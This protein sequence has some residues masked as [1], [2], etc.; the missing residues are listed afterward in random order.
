MPHFAVVGFLAAAELGAEFHLQRH[1]PQ[2]HAA[3]QVKAQIVLAVFGLL[4]YLFRLVK[5]ELRR[6]VHA[7]RADQLGLA[8]VAKAHLAEIVVRLEHCAGNV[9]RRIFAGLAA[10]QRQIQLPVAQLLFAAKHQ[11]HDVLGFLARFQ[12]ACAFGLARLC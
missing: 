7:V 6:V 2:L 8:R 3:A 1:T 12:L 10:G 5:R 11:R 9:F 4:F